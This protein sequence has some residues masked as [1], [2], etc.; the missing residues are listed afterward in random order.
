MAQTITVNVPHKLGKGEAKRR[1]QEGFGAMRQFEVGGLPGLLSFEKRWEGD[2]FR[3]VAGGLGQRISS[4]LD[5]LDDSI[6][7]HVDIPVLLAAI[8]ERIKAAVTKETAKALEH[9]K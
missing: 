4:T 5:V 6:Q 3:F 1:I 7:I 9:S 2:Q 8:A